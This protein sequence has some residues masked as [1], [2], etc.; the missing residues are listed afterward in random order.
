MADAGKRGGFAPEGCAGGGVV[1]ARDYRG[2]RRYSRRLSET[3]D[4]AAD[5]ASR[6]RGPR[7]MT[8]AS[9]RASTTR[10][11]AAL[12][13]CT[14]SSWNDSLTGG[15]TTAIVARDTKRR[16]SESSHR[17]HRRAGCDRRV[18]GVESG[19][20]CARSRDGQEH[21]GLVELARR[22]PLGQRVGQILD[23]SP[24]R[25]ESQGHVEAERRR[26][27]VRGDH[28]PR[29]PVKGPDAGV[30]H[31]CCK[32]RGH[33]WHRP[34][35]VVHHGADNAEASFVTHQRH[36]VYRALS[37]EGHAELRIA[38]VPQRLGGPHHRGAPHTRDLGELLSRHVHR[39]GDIGSDHLGNPELA[40]LERWRQGRHARR[41]RGVR[42]SCPRHAPSPP[43]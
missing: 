12:D 2:A 6:A 18:D 19:A 40:R 23:R 37:R 17:H 29:R 25:G 10:V 36:C 14:S 35:K 9:T 15:T 1:T 5:L 43:P 42:R 27:A 41:R 31:V 33:V 28:D 11:I 7:C 3:T 8:N 32:R 26:E 30:D 24:R 4:R 39:A 34:R 20:L 38:V 22:D 16:P 21:A 13:V